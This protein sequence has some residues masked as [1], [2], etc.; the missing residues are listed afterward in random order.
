MRVP[1]VAQCFVYGDSLQRLGSGLGRGLGLGLGLG[2]RL[3]LAKP[4][5]HDAMR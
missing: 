3:G 4:N 5:L 1:L 2:L